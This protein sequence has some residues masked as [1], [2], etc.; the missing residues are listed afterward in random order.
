MTN[1]TSIIRVSFE[2]YKDGYVATSSTLNGLF[3]AHRS[4]AEVYD[5]VPVAIKL[6][7]KAMYGTDVSVKEA[8][9]ISEEKQ[10]L[11]G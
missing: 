9:E 5:A 10:S 7:F 11:K 2:R 3:V 8:A 4:L 1:T 6:L